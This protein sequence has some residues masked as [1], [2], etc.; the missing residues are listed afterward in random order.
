MSRLPYREGTWFAVPLRE[1]GFAVGR[2]ARMAPRGRILLGYFFGPR[3]SAIPALKTVERLKLQQAIWAKRFGYLGLF[4]GHW[5]IIGDSE[6]WNREE[7]PMPEFFMKDELSKR[8]YRVVYSGN[9]LQKMV[10]R[11]LVPYDTVEKSTHG[12]AGAEFVE[13][14][15]DKLLSKKN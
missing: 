7:W 1:D 11:T 6:N 10:E 4:E 5:P 9:D 3:L 13:I 8:A 2:I 15:L 12:L 14:V